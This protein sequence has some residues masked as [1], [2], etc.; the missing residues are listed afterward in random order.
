[1]HRKP[2]CEV[3]NACLRRA[4][5]RDFGERSECVHRR[6]IDDVSARLYHV[7]DKHLRHQECRRNVEV[8]HK[9]ESALVKCEKVLCAFEVGRHGFVVSGCFGIVSAGSVYEKVD[10]AELVFDFVFRAENIRF[11]KTVALD[12]VCVFAYL[13]RNFFG[14]VVVD[15]Q[16]RDFCAALGERASKLGANNSARSRDCHDFVA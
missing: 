13:V 9:F 11:V 10:F 16:K 3:G 6:D 2:L 7:F 4:V 5:R 1:M 12:G 15:V 8:E 14:S